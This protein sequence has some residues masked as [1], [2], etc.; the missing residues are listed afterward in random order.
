[1]R[2]TQQKKGFKVLLNSVAALTS[3]SLKDYPAAAGYYKTVLSIDPTD[4]VSHYPS[5]RRRF[6][7]GSPAATDGFWELA[8]SIALKAPN[9]AQVQT[10]LK[11][12]LIRYQQPACDKLVDD[13]V[14][15]LITLAG[16][17]ADNLPRLI[18][19]APRT[20]RRRVTIRP[21]SCRTLRRAAM[22]AK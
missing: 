5:R 15:E 14:N 9:A 18:S 7:N 3:T 6:A 1:M 17:S 10:Y 19:P 12:Q 2:S 20:C 11:N 13:Q 16:S 4:A 8:R 22:R 21:I